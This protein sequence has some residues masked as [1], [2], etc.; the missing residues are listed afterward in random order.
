LVEVDSHF[1]SRLSSQPPEQLGLQVYTW[2]SFPN[3]VCRDGTSFTVNCKSEDHALEGSQRQELRQACHQDLT[4]VA[5]CG[6]RLSTV[7]LNAAFQLLLG[8]LSQLLLQNCNF[9]TCFDNILIGSF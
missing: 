5:G 2:P 7:V 3:F 9:Q 8:G 6:G 4:R 1:L